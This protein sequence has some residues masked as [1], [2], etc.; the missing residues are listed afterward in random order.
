M[1]AGWIASLCVALLAPESA[2]A[3]DRG[4]YVRLAPGFAWTTVEHTKEVSVGQVG[5]GSTSTSSAPELSL[6]LAGGFRGQRGS[7]WFLGLEVEALIYAPRTITGDIAPQSV[8]TPIGIDPGEWQYINKR[9]VG[10]NVVI[11]R[12]LNRPDR[13]LL[14][15]AGVHRF[16]TEVASGGTHGGTGQFEE[17]RE[18]RS[19]W[20]LT[21]GAGVALGP[22]NLR[23]SYFR[24]L[25]YWGF[26]SPEIEVTYNWRA[27][28]V[29]AS[30]GVEVF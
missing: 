14:F 27:S 2:V 1:H 9:G 22:V 8:N 29:V 18:V 25:I 15:F 26:L 5:S 21:G 30:L 4:Y 13:R 20:P 23:V 10:V 7:N 3:Q 17:D 6:H 19:R 24:S 11:E 12:V 16:Q 28:G